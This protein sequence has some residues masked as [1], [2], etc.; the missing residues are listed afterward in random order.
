MRDPVEIKVLD[1]VLAARVVK[2]FGAG[3]RPMKPEKL[4]ALLMKLRKG[5]GASIKGAELDQIFAYL[6][7]WRIDEAQMWVPQ[8]GRYTPADEVKTYA[9]IK[10]EDTEEKHKEAKANEVSSLP[11]PDTSKLYSHVYMDVSPLGM[12]SDGKYYGFTAREWQNVKSL[13]FKDPKGNIHEEEGNADKFLQGYPSGHLFRWLKAN[14][15]FYDQINE[16]LNLPSYEEEKEQKRRERAPKVDGNMGTCPACFGTFKLLPKTKRGHDKTMP[17][18]VLHG[19]KRPGTGYI[20]GN[21]FGQDWPPFELSKEGTE[22]FLE[23]LKNTEDD[24]EKAISNLKAGRIDTLYVE[25]KTK[26]RA[27]T[28]EDPDWAKVLKSKIEE[29]EARLSNIQFVIGI[30]KKNLAGWKPEPLPP[31]GTTMKYPTL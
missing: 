23:A 15:V 29:N 22:A 31:P 20:H 5:A 7:G 30:V 1:R 8:G 14:R 13:R 10:Q 16:K 6:G 25:E 28:R 9:F 17:G 21:C 3:K 26:M 2:R 4:Q 12:V 27:V 24:V 18:M 19:Y 11:D